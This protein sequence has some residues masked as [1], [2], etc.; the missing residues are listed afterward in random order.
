V[1]WYYPAQHLWQKGTELYHPEHGI[2]KLAFRDDEGRM[3]FEFKEH[4]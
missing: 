4:A 1:W 3:M 2:G